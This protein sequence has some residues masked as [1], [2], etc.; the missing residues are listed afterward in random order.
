MAVV[1]SCPMDLRLFPMD[2]QARI[3]SNKKSSSSRTLE[4]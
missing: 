2:R 3:N 4:Q 1:V